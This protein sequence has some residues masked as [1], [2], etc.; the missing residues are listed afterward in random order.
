M[1]RMDEVRAHQLFGWE[2]RLASANQKRAACAGWLIK[3]LD[4]Y[5][6]GIKPIA[7]EES[8]FLRLPVLLPD[9]TIKEAVCRQSWEEGA[10]LSPNYPATIQDIPELAGRLT[11]RSYPGAQEVVDRLVTLPTHQFVRERDL[12]KVDRVLGNRGSCSVEVMPGIPKHAEEQ[13]YSGTR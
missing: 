9:R 2:Q 12:Q 4:L 13:S 8:I 5:R 1:F 10:G 3:G 6:R 7:G 11:S